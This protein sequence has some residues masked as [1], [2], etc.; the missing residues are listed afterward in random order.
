MS[1]VLFYVVRPRASFRVH[2]PLIRLFHFAL[3]LT[4]T[5]I[6]CCAQLGF[7]GGRLAIR[8]ALVGMTEVAAA[9]S[10][11]A[12][13]HNQF[14]APV[15]P[16]GVAASISHKRHMAVALV[17]HDCEGSVGAFVQV[18]RLIEKKVQFGR[19]DFCGTI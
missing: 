5:Y 12:I 17:Q 3:V 14:G 2:P 18:L 15:L 9:A 11:M 4:A 16:D 7:L 8:R 6:Y 10:S 13:L 1:A 19:C